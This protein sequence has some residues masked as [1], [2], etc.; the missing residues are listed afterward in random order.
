MLVAKPKSDK[1]KSPSQWLPR[2]GSGTEADP[3]RHH[4]EV[5]EGPRPKNNVTHFAG[6]VR[7]RPLLP[8]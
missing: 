1:A 5:A 2:Q 6:V 7:R 3:E 8:F 4:S